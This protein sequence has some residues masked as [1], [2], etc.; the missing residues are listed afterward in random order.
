MT[1]TDERPAAAT[2][3]SLWQELATWPLR[4]WIFAAAMA[5]GTVVVVAIVTVLIPNPWFVREI[6]PTPWA[7]PVLITTGLLSGLVAATYVA[8]KD[9]AQQRRSG[10]LGMTGTIAAFFAV[11]CPVCNKLVLIALGYAGA[12]QFFEPL[13]PYLA[14]GAIVLLGI[15]FVQRV[16]R[17]SACPLPSVRA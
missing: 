16:R 11:G 5:T 17:E 7:W 2:Q 4:R 3:R 8:R 6:P 10:V 13:Q 1:T 12:L 14:G 9:E 15:A